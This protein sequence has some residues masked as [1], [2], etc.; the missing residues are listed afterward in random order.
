VGQAALTEE[1]TVVSNPPA[2]YV[3]IRS[4]LGE[5]GARAIV[6]LPL[7]HVGRV[8]GIVE[9]ALFAPWSDRAREAMEG[10]RETLTIAIEVARA[11]AATRELLAETQRQAERLRE[12]EEELR[13][14]N[15]ELQ[16]QQEELRQTN[17]ELTAQTEEL[18]IQR[19]ALERNNAELDDARKN[20]ERKAAEL[21]SVSA[22]KSQFLA[23]MSHELRT[24]LNSM[25]L[26]SNLLAENDENTLNPKQVEFA[27]TIH[28]AG[29]DLLALINQVLDLAK[30]EAGKHDVRIGPVPLRRITQ[31][32]Q[33]IFEP[34]ALDKGLGFSVE[35]APDLPDAIST[36]GQRLEQILN[37]LMGNA[38]KFTKKGQVG[39][40]VGPADL[41]ARFGRPDLRPER[42]LAFAVTDTGLGIAVENQDRI[43]APFEQVDGAIDRR[44]GG[45]GLGLSISRE[46]SGL[47]GGELQLRTELGVGSTFTCYL[48]REG[49]AVT[50]SSASGLDTT[51]RAPS[52]AQGTRARPGD[53]GPRANGTPL[54]LLVE[55]DR[56]FAETLSEIIIEQ[57]L[58]CVIAPDGGA[59]LRLARERRPTGII[60]DVRLPDIDG[61]EVLAQLRADP[62]TDRIPVH[63]VSAV[64]ATERGAALGV[65]GHVQKPASRG[66]LLRVIDSLTRTTDQAAKRVLVVEDD[67]ATGDS[68]ASQ[69]GGDKF[70]VLRAMTAADALDIL[71]RERIRCIVLDLG[72]PDMDGLQLLRKLH[73]RDG[74]EMPPVVVYTARTLNAE[75]TRT[76]ETYA[77]S[78][79]LKEGASTDR[80]LDE[81]RLFTRHLKETSASRRSGIESAPA[82]HI[83]LVGRRI[84]V[85]D[86][87]MR[88][89]YALSAVLRAKGAEV[90]LADNG[91]A[92][93]DALAQARTIDVVLM[94]IMM[95]VMDG[96]E[97]IRQIRRIARFREVPI[98]ALTAKAMKDD[99][100]KCIQAGA[101]EY[102][103]KPVD[104]E[105]LLAMLDTFF[106]KGLPDGG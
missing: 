79:V 96:Y 90:T 73:E 19:E 94:D 57:G 58:D 102:L 27:K 60:L 20:L 83:N 46:L 4:G 39:L 29:R 86:D 106:K 78:V 6:L 100:D 62:A 17:E 52:A 26:L 22:Y 68:V 32:V 7:S 30:I 49:P 85:A 67:V 81:V 21:T 2:D 93:L 33:R 28:T 47:L 66:D 8:R 76:L 101:T 10:V 75:E 50:E 24:P 35:V 34:L 18:E 104:S 89:V 43:F 63:V 95:P 44:Y 84:L 31:H 80:L 71:A 51:P 3:R 48:P 64:D 99:P 103:P 9:L 38:I 13:S 72:L 54:L 36:D 59:A 41:D 1:I 23:N 5:G 70:E 14:T 12:Q 55:D 87:D 74:I 69:L 105:R 65:I 15:E 88:T 37:N 40:R 61:W 92:A 53:R 97:A 11:R 16:S 42:T 98:V 56:T 91:Q 25:L 77:A 45:T 82:G